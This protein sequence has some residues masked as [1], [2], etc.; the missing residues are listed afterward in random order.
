MNCPTETLVI[1]VTAPGPVDDTASAF[2][3]VPKSGN[4]STNDVIPTGSTYGQPAPLT[5]ATILVGPSGTYTFTA[6]VA[7]TYTYTIPVCAPGQTSNCPTETLV[8]TVTAPGPVDDTATAFANVAKA[9]EISTNDSNPAGTTFGQPAALTGATITVAANG[10]YTFT[11]TVAGT[12]TYTIPV[13]APGQTVN[14][15]TETLVITVTEPT[16]VN[17]TASTTKNTAITGNVCL[18]YTS[19]AADE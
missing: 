11:A 14:C 3:N 19:D 1:T 9:G 18:L 17:D 8:I 10:T 13:C 6:T 15:P 5:G 2:A 4:V 12:Y 7:G 16:P